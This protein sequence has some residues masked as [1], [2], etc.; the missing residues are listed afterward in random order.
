M[1]VKIVIIQKLNGLLVPRIV[2][3]PLTGNYDDL[4]VL[5]LAKDAFDTIYDQSP[6]MLDNLNY[7]LILFLNEQLTKLNIELDVKNGMEIDAAQFSDGL[8]LI[9]LMGLC[10]DFFVPLGNIYMT[11][12]N[13]PLNFEQPDNDP[14]DKLINSTNY[15]NSSSYHKL[16]N[17]NV[18]FQL[19]EDAGIQV[20]FRDL[21][22][23]K[24]ELFDINAIVFPSASV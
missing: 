3:E 5:G 14:K 22:I 24:I 19:I 23:T 10:E 6:E 1:N 13:A 4:G 18:A 15:I 12:N 7:H 16:H 8:L 21:Q 11:P 9:F 20:N 17:M 2:S